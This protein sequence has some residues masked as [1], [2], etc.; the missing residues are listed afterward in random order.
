MYYRSINY[1]GYDKNRYDDCRDLI[2]NT[3]YRHL[4]I[5]NTWLLG[6]T[7]TFMILSR[8]N[9]FGVTMR[10]F[11]L[12][13][14]FTII[15][16][17][18]EVVLIVFKDFCIRFAPVFTHI[19]ILLLMSFSIYSSM[20]QPYLT[21][22]MFLVLIVLVAVSYI[23]TM[24]SITV[25]LILYSSAFLYTSF[26]F[27][28]H[29]LAELDVYNVT[30]FLILA[31]VLHYTFQRTKMQQF[32][33][34]QK[35]IQIQR[36]L[37]IRSSFDTLTD[38]LNRARFFSIATEI[39]GKYTDKNEYIAV[40]LLDLDSF[41]QINDTLGH[42]MGDKAIQMTASIVAEALNIDMLEKWSF[43]KRAVRDKI[44]F[45][46]RLGGDEYI[47]FIRGLNNDDEVRTLLEGVLKK[48]NAVRIGGLNG[49]HGSFGA[50]S[51]KSDD[52][53][54][55]TAYNRADKALYISKEAGKNRVTFG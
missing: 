39:V 21:A 6:L 12:Y 1:Y 55:D 7:I 25:L 41:K 27:K 43:S 13:L 46:G 33:T 15:S 54:I 53:D 26:T 42:Q 30:V 23:G 29:S 8:L 36:D 50:T 19:N 32:Y 14:I 20:M 35:N 44:S 5:I 24:I 40:C 49:I 22:T 38:L 47:L 16:A 3:N 17:F 4:M 37:E 18:L 52:K 28:S 11:T 34:L 31:L 2:N 48:L 51:L 10:N 45:A 9:L